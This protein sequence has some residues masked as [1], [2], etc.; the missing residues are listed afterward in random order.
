MRY[1]ELDLFGIYVAPIAPMM[2]A[3][4]LV[5]MPLRW[6]AQRTGITRHVWHHALFGFSV[7]LM[8]L[9]AIVVGVGA[10]NHAGGLDLAGSLNLA[11]LAN[12][13]RALTHG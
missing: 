3:A 12:Y 1:A 11:G 13:A 10:L 2:L 5:M 8:V 4:W 9:A 6:I 7:Y